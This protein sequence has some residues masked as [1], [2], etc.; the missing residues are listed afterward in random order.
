[1]PCPRWSENLPA[2]TP[3][4]VDSIDVLAKLEA[5][6]FLINQKICGVKDAALLE[7]FFHFGDGYLRMVG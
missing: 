6:D 4:R 2:I 7:R 5:A 1:M 3:A